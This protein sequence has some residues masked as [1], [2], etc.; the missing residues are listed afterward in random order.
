MTAKLVQAL[1]PCLQ[2]AGLAALIL[3]TGVS[4]A[5]AEAVSCTINAAA[6]AQIAGTYVCSVYC[7][8]VG[9]GEMETVAQN[10]ASLTFTNAGGSVAPGTISPPNASGVSTGSVGSPWDLTFTVDATCQNITFSNTTIWTLQQTLVIAQSLPQG[11]AGVPYP[12]TGQSAQLISGGTPPYTVSATGLPPGLTVGSDGAVSGTPAGTDSGTYQIVVSVTDSA[13]AS[14]AGSVSVTINQVQNWTLSFLSPSAGAVE[15][16]KVG[17]LVQLQAT[18]NAPGPQTLNLEGII[19]PVG[20]GTYSQSTFAAASFPAPWELN[21]CDS[22]YPN[23]SPTT[24]PTKL[25]NTCQVFATY[26][27]SAKQVVGAGESV[28]LSCNAAQ[29]WNWVEPL[30]LGGI[31][32]GAVSGLITSAAAKAWDLEWLA[33]PI[34]AGMDVKEATNI[35][36]PDYYTYYASISQPQPPGSSTPP[37]VSQTRVV[38]IVPSQAQIGFFAESLG[39]AFL[40]DATLDSTS[41]CLYATPLVCAGLIAATAGEFGAAYADRNKANDPRYDIRTIAAPTFA[42]TAGT[43]WAAQSDSSNSS[44]GAQVA[45]FSQASSLAYAL[46]L[47]AVQLREIGVAEAQLSTSLTYDSLEDAALK[48]LT[49]EI[50]RGVPKLTPTQLAQLASAL[51]GGALPAPLAQAFTAAGI[52]ATDQTAI[53]QSLAA[54]VPNLAQLAS[55]SGQ[56]LNT[57]S[58]TLNQSDQQLSEDLAALG[59]VVGVEF[60]PRHVSSNDRYIEA[61]ISPPGDQA[62][63]IDLASIRLGFNL[64]AWDA[65]ILNCAGGKAVVKATFDLLASGA[66]TLKNGINVLP[67]TGQFISSGKAF[68]TSGIVTLVPA[69]SD[70]AGNQQAEA[71]SSNATADAVNNWAWGG[72]DM[73]CKAH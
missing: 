54:N 37:V 40:G 15:T 7:P 58:S 12:P 11:L 22:I 56:L 21:Y 70:A 36:A 60:H 52:S 5:W 2:V 47:G 1:R 48:S 14:A 66:P 38:T 24:C 45:A 16:M 39:W 57:V 71:A 23:G 18:N 32:K 13:G 10:G 34:A 64:P 26:G 43:A 51:Q 61:W 6:V 73:E 50:S 68:G 46:Y 49:S 31:I 62:A 55:Q 29:N 35:L 30:T 19:N 72:R 41:L 69:H 20:T 63:S 17:Y 27:A 9:I 59:P 44:A 65:K 28:T 67:V 3:L 53:A 8:T 33:N 4:T 42:G 25:E